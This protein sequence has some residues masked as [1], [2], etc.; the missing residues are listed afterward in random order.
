MCAL[1]FVSYLLTLVNKHKVHR[2]CGLSMKTDN[3][4]LMHLH[5]PVSLSGINCKK[6]GTVMPVP[7]HNTEGTEEQWR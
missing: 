5:V 6:K 3:Q 1:Q 7:K 2:V 4:S